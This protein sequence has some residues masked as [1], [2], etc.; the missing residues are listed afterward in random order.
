MFKRFAITSVILATLGVQAQAGDQFVD[1]TGFAVSG[2]DVV[3]YHGLQ[4]SS[5]GQSQPA[6][7]AGKASLT[8]EY[9][10]A[11]FAFATEANRDA[12]VADPAKF[13]PQYDGHCAYGV[14]KGGKVPGNP[15][16]WRI[17]DGK[18]YLNITTAVV[19]FWEEDIPGNL[20]KSETNWTSLEPADASNAVIPNYSSP[21]PEQN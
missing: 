19:G 5:V 21:A 11:K 1:A 18:L 10:G 12:F 6:P 8:A 13:A 7:L 15:T 4:Q 16:L 17:V 20:V 3:S 2:F 14:A 9:N